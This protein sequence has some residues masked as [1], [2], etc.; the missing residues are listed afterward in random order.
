MLYTFTGGAD[1][2]FPNGVVMGGKGYL[3]GTAGYGAANGGLIFKMSLSGQETVLYN[4]T[5]G[6]DGGGPKRRDLDRQGNIYGTTYVGGTEGFGVVYKL[7]TSGRQTVLYSFPGGPE[8]ALPAGSLYRDAAG[9]LYGTTTAGGGA[10]GE[11]GYGVVFKVD[12]SGA[13]TVLYRFTGQ[14]DG[15]DPFSGV[16]GDA[17]GNLYGVTMDGGSESCFNGCGVVYQVTPSGQETVLYSF[18]GGADGQNPY[19]PLVRDAAGN[20]YG[21]TPYGGNGGFGAVSFSGGGVV[22]QGC[23]LR[24]APKPKRSDTIGRVL[25]RLNHR[26]ACAQSK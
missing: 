23:A 26:G 6:A 16:V 7:D 10:V 4:F 12:V 19:D 3:Y 20:L 9:N 17:A 2:G 25:L 22:V 24:N 14:A 11:A 18:T 1:G 21:T 13:Y 5:D 8:G 15:G